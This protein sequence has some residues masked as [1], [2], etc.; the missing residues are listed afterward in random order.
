MGAQGRT[1]P[2]LPP[3]PRAVIDT[4]LHSN[5]PAIRTLLLDLRAPATSGSPDGTTN[6]DGQ[7]SLHPARQE[8]QSNQ[9]RQPRLSLMAEALMLIRGQYGDG[10]FAAMGRLGDNPVRVTRGTTR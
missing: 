3:K 8:Y 10:R 7:S 6:R 5:R 2:P 1:T 4:P 9:A